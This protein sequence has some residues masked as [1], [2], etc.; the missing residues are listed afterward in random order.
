MNVFSA[1]KKRRS[2]R[3]FK[4]KKIPFKALEK[5]VEAARLSPTARNLQPL[6][7]VVVQE[8]KNREAALGCIRL[9]GVV[10]EK[11]IQK[12]EEPK[13][14]I[15]ILLNRQK[16]YDYSINDAGI[17]VQSICLSAFEQGL[18]TC[19]IG[20]VDRQKLAPLLGLPDNC[21]IVLAVAL[22]YPKEKPRIAD[23]N[24]KTQYWTE[25]GDLVVPKRSLQSIMHR[26]K[27]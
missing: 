26:E 2:I 12:G 11:G 5:C 18:G 3:R 21:E 13:A 17:A 4:E 10:A 27:Y 22:G 8:K 9:G 15:V 1:I 19:I 20:S 7:F 6:E 16:A 25:K 23:E 14:F 24:G